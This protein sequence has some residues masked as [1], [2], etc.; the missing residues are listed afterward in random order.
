[1]KKSTIFFI[2]LLSAWADA[3]T[4]IT[5][6]HYPELAESN[7]RANPFLET[8]FVLGGQAI[9]LYAGEKIKANP[10]IT[11]AI[12]LTVTIPPFYAAANNLAHVAV[13][14]ARTYPWKTCPLLY[15][16]K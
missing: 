13:I 6:S 4:T 2:G 7:P 1:M 14:E 10:K 9:I 5:A 15:N 8:A 16:G 11:K 3:A 12:A